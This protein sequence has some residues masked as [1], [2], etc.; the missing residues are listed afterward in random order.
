MKMFTGQQRLAGGSQAIAFSFG[1]LKNSSHLFS[2]FIR[3][4]TTFFFKGQ[5]AAVCSSVCRR[6]TVCTPRVYKLAQTGTVVLF[7]LADFLIACTYR[8]EGGG[9]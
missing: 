7:D 6:L 5:Y 9:D 4:S 1:G 2:I 8:S 3:S